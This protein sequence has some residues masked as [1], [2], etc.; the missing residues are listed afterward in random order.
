M[1]RPERLNA[2]TEA[3]LWMPL[4]LG[5]GR[6]AFLNTT[7]VHRS[8][9]LSDRCGLCARMERSARGCDTSSTNRCYDIGERGLTLRAPEPR[10]CV[11]NEAVLLLGRLGYQRAAR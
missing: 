6:K 10:E 11:S 9:D 7:L 4:L 5:A 1:R 2:C 8:V 3:R